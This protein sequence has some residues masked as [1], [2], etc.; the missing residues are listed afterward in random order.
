MTLQ[1]VRDQVGMR[2]LKI[3][4][5]AWDHDHKPKRKPRKRKIRR[6]DSKDWIRTPRK[7]KLKK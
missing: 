4:V 5:A 7:P 1:A 3:F 6:L 2:Y